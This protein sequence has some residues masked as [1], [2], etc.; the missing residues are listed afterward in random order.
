MKYDLKT[1][2][3]YMFK[4]RNFGFIII[5]LP[6]LLIFGILSIPAGIGLVIF[7]VALIMLFSYY[8]Y[9][10]HKRIYIKQNYPINLEKTNV[11]L[12]IFLNST[13]QFLII[14]PVIFSIFFKICS[15]FPITHVSFLGV[16]IALPFFPILIFGY[17]ISSIVYPLTLDFKSF[18]DFKKIKSIITNDGSEFFKYIGIVSLAIISCIV[19][20]LVTW[21]LGGPFVIVYI[22]MV[23]SDIHA[24]FLRKVFKIEM[25]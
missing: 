10:T 15:L 7:P 20:T 13:V 8:L 9:N 23:L 21:L 17:T 11:Y 19:L 12:K 25:E 24:Q 4:E 5:F 1:A 14:T 16:L 22:A 3:T 2:F 18:Y 6:L